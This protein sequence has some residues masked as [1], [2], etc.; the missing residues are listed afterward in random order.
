MSLDQD[1][2]ITLT[3]ALTEKIDQNSLASDYHTLRRGGVGLDVGVIA[4]GIGGEGG[5]G[6]AVSVGKSCFNL[7]IFVKRSRAFFGAR[8]T[9]DKG[10][11][12]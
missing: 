3:D 5:G 2:S 6:G 10:G 9:G 1:Q 11:Q 12:V 4:N 8:P 7:N